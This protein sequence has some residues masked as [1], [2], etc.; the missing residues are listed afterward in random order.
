MELKKILFL[1]KKDKLVKKLKAI[2]GE[3]TIKG[4]EDD[5][6]EEDVE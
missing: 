5:E 6:E 3:G 1:K 2:F 4:D